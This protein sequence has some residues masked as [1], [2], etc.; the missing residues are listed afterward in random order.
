[1]S[2]FSTGR[3]F[4]DRYPFVTSI[5]AVLFNKT[6][7]FN[8]IK[9][10]GK[11]NTYSCHRSF[12]RKSKI[13]VIGRGNSIEFGEKCYCETCK[14]TIL[15]N[16]NLIKLGNRV[17][18]KDA[19]LYIEDSG[20]E[21]IINYRTSI[22]GK[23]HLACTEGKKIIIGEHCMFSSDVVLRTG[24]SHSIVDLDGKRINHAKDVIVGDHVWVGNK[25]IL[26]KGS[27]VSDNS[28]VAT[29]A[30]VTKVFEKSN[31]IL[32][33]SPAEIIK[34]DINWLEERI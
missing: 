2:I 14:I 11:N 4:L 32:A 6:I 23:T 1:M 3:K 7:G 19:D 22:C 29:G 18:L 26:T 27:R 16:N 20:N 21:I 8:S 13:T 12:L 28:I 25:T 15:G 34:E 31:V 10:K 9:I 24:D 5:S 33:G 30:I 17:Y